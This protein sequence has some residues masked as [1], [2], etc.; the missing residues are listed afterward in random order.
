MVSAVPSGPI[1][2]Q[3]QA[4]VFADAIHRRAS[5]PSTSPLPISR[6]AARVSDLVAKMVYSASPIAQELGNRVS[7]WSGPVS[8]RTSAIRTVGARNAPRPAETRR[9][10][11]H[12]W[13]ARRP[14]RVCG[15]QFFLLPAALHHGY[16]FFRGFA[17]NDVPV[18]HALQRVRMELWCG[19][20]TSI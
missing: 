8:R 18:G 5:H 3:L 15:S 13:V 6:R 10:I 17:G 7:A 11:T 19:G 4:P 12:S 14:P 16:H 2:L 9:A 1:T 20:C